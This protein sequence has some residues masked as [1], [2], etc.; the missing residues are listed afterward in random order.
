MI[1]RYFSNYEISS[2]QEKEK[3]AKH[4]VK[5]KKQGPVN[6]NHNDLLV[7][8]FNGGVYIRGV[9]KKDSKKQLVPDVI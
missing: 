5:A 9:S 1:E 6:G 4:S 8:L 2:F 7:A 3:K